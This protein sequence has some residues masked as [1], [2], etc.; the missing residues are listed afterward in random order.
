[1]KRIFAK[2]LN[3]ENFDYRI[4]DIREDDGNELYV[5]GG[6][7]FCDIDENG[8][9]SAIKK[10]IDE[11]NDYYF[12]VYYHNSMKEFLLDMLPKKENGKELSPKEIHYL[13]E[14]LDKGDKDDIRCACLSIIRGKTY[15]WTYLRGCC[16]GDVVKAY[17]P[18]TE[19]Q[20][21]VDFVEAWFFGTGTEIE[22]HDGDFDPEAPEDIEGF[23]FYTATWKLDE[24]KEEI[25]S[26][27]GYKEDDD[28]EIVLWLYDK[29]ITIKHDTYKL[30]D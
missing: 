5:F 13:K 6:R 8:Y 30:A 29:T 17:Y 9:L 2:T 27:C 26:A 1:M 19:T 10:I 16:Q 15:T 28:V 20:K 4:Y 23:T 21:Y 14:V 3:P 7:D 11:Y 18:E 12:E 25:K 22:I 24:L